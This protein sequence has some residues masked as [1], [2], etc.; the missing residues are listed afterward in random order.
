MDVLL[1]WRDG[2]LTIYTVARALPF[3][4]VPVAVATR[5]P[6][7]RGGH[8]MGA[9]AGS[10]VHHFRRHDVHLGARL[11]VVYVEEPEG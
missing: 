10:V 8:A 2:V 11:L 5:R 1:S 3:L 9:I 7:A 4:D 6:R